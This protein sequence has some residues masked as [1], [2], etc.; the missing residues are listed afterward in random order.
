MWQITLA[1]LTAD[2]AEPIAKHNR[3]NGVTDWFCPFCNLVVGIES[4]GSVHD[5]GWLYKRDECKNGHPIKWSD[6]D[7]A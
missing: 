7:G 5:K 1:E 3:L 4:D 6:T 2:A